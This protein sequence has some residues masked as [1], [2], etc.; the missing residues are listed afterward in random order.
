MNLL[1][2]SGSTPQDHNPSSLQRRASYPTNLYPSSQEN[3]TIVPG[4]YLFSD[5]RPFNGFGKAG[6]RV[7]RKK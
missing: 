4:Q 7:T 3:R 1:I 5:L 2:H 6:H